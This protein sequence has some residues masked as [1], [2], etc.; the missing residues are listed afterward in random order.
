MGIC[1]DFHGDLRWFN[2]QEG[3]PSANVRIFEKWTITMLF[4]FV[5]PRLC[6]C[7]PENHSAKWRSVFLSHT[8]NY[9][10]VF[11]LPIILL[12]W[13]GGGANC[14]RLPLGFYRGSY[15][16]PRRKDLPSFGS[17]T[18]H[19]EPNSMDIIWD[20]IVWCYDLATK[21]QSCPDLNL[22]TH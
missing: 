9:W 17:M 13:D 16:R 10:R 3:L 2:W 20:P 6:W 8:S 4:F 5:N 19:S 7:G 1:I 21:H 11:W 14:N 15:G 22:W 18:F 12:L